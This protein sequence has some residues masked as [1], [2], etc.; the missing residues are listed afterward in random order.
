[1]SDW[2]VERGTVPHLAQVERVGVEMAEESW[3]LGASVAA[4]GASGTDAL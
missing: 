4:G 3:F 1:M 2:M